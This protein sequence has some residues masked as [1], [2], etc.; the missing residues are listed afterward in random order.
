VL[1]EVPA[2]TRGEGAVQA[3]NHLGI[4]VDSTSEVEAEAARLRDA[5][6]VTLDERDTTCCHALQ[7]KVWVHDPA[8]APWEV[9]TVKDE[10]PSIERKHEAVACC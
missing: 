6:L 9:Y 1:I 7:D 2:D 4:E 8:G 10:N 5:G 3:L